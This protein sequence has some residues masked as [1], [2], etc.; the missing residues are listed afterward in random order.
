MAV[1]VPVRVPDEV[2]VAIVAWRFARVRGVDR[3]NAEQAA[4]PAEDAANRAPDHR[5]D[6]PGGV[7]SDCS[8]VSRTIGNTLGLGRN[9][10]GQ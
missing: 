1:D 2:P 6:R 8:A 5:A 3:L 9:R 10:G 4:D 7:G